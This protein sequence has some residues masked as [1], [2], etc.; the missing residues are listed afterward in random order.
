[1][2]CKTKPVEPL[3]CHWVVLPLLL[4]S[5]VCWYCHH[6]SSWQAEKQQL[7]REGSLFCCHLGCS[8]S[9]TTAWRLITAIKDHLFIP[10]SSEH[11]RVGRTRA[12]WQ[13]LTQCISV[14][15]YTM[16][17]LVRCE[18]FHSECSIQL[19][20]KASL[21]K[22]FYQETTEWYACCPWLS[23]SCSSGRGGLM[24]SIPALLHV[25]TFCPVVEPCGTLLLPTRTLWQ[26]VEHI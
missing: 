8:V 11:A 15:K 1:M 10:L 26:C 19:M 21:T 25:S 18:W 9:V 23:W 22:T 24:T 6:V 2:A 13:A 5:P 3:E 14:I 20:F 16:V 4:V 7:Q 12:W 17:L